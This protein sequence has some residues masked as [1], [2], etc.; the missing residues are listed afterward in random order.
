MDEKGNILEE[1]EKENRLLRKEIVRLEGKLEHHQKTQRLGAWVAGRA[2][3]AVIGWNLSTRIKDWI[4]TYKRIKPE[5]PI[6]ETA[7]VLEG[8]LHRLIRVG[9]WTL[10][11]GLVPILLLLWQNLLIGDQNQYFREQIA[12]M[13]EQDRTARRAQL[14][15]T[16]YDEDCSGSSR[17][18]DGRS[19]CEMVASLRAREEAVKAFIALERLQGNA[20]IDLYNARLDLLSLTG[21]DLSGINLEGAFAKNANLEK[22]D[23]SSTNLRRVEFAGAN[24][25]GANLTKA[26][27]VGTRLLGANLEGTNLKGATYSP[28]TTTWPASIN[29]EAAGA[30]RVE[31]R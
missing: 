7:R 5:I 13:R 18:R 6:D 25:S 9:L 21:A 24:L 17:V 15:A 1:V 11:V 20:E 28:Y 2:L 14:I 23:L 16:I 10:V 4:E 26:N 8:I 12:E 31:G 27:L 22:A 3:K 29:L 19:Q 30:I